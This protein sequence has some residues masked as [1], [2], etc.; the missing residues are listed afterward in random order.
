MPRGRCSGRTAHAHRAIAHWLERSKGAS[1][2]AWILVQPRLSFPRMPEPLGFQPKGRATQETL[3]P[4]ISTLVSARKR[5]Q[6][7]DI[8][9]GDAI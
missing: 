4:Q 2:N 5:R 7:S 8:A 3:T 9:A 6:Q 1:Q